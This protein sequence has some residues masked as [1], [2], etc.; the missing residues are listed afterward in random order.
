MNRQLINIFLLYL[1]LASCTSTENLS[2][3]NNIPEGSDPHYFP[4]EIPDYQL[5]ARDILYLTIKGMTPDGMVEDLLQGNRTVN[6][7]AYLNSESSQYIVGYTVD[8]N[9]DLLIPVIGKLNVE[10]QTLEQVREALQEKADIFFN[11]AFVD[12]KLLSFKFTVLGEVINP[13]SFV[14]YNNHLTVF[15]A[16]GRAGGIN[17]FGRRDKL[18]VLR[19]ENDNTRVYRIDLQDKE[20]LSSEAYFLKPND[21]VIV[22]P[23][24]H[25]IFNLN[26]PTYSF[27]IA[28][29]TSTITT[30]LLL[31]NFF[32]K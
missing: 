10:G 9:G 21:V 15:E 25:R 4:M 30:T 19:Y 24:N 16:I 32:G 14:N 3:L 22:E 6:Q 11:N 2:Y 5:Q 27:F 13:G 23:V 7:T 20:L 29:V 8:K 26:L 1:I 28:T 17:N 31:I 12:V 18:M